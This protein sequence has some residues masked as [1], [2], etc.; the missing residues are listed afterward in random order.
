MSLKRTKCSYIN[1]A[2]QHCTGIDNYIYIEREREMD[3]WMG[4]WVG[5]WMDGWMD[6]Q[7]TMMLS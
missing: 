3:G 4:G 2:G 1:T 7:W 6:E 5:W